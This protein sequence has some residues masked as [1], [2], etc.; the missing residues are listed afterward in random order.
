[1]AGNQAYG[2]VDSLAAYDL[3]RL[4]T[5]PYMRCVQTL[6]PLAAQR[7]VE[8]ELR[9]ELTEGASREEALA[10]IEELRGFST[11][12]CTHG[13]VVLE[14]LGSELRKGATAILEP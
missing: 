12:L 9:D 8:L 4:V 10:L 14:I 13:D 6:E 7:G 5:S 11:A 2:L 3:D 1:V